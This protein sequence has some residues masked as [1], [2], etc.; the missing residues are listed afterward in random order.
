[1]KIYESKHNVYDA[2][3]AFLEHGVVAIGGTKTP[4]IDYINRLKECL[5]PYEDIEP[6]ESYVT[7]SNHGYLYFLYDLNR[8]KLK[9]KELLETIHYIDSINPV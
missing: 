6:I 1:M 8:F 3:D 5:K 9:S 2:V 7:V 4:A